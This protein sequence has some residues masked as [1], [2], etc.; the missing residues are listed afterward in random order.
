MAAWPLRQRGARA[1]LAGPA[2]PLAQ[3]AGEGERFFEG[4]RLG[5][6]AVVGVQHEGGTVEDEFVLPANLVHVDQ[7]QVRLADAGDGEVEAG[8]ALVALE[9][10]AVD[11]DHDLGSRF[12]E[13]FGDL[14]EPH[15]L[16]D[17]GPEADAAKRYRPRQA[18]AR[19]DP[20]LVEDPVV[21][22]L[23]LVAACRDLAAVEQQRGI[24][25]LAVLD[26]GGAQE[27]RRAAVGSRRGERLHGSPRLLLEHRL[28]HEV[29]GG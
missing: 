26:P 6:E 7:R 12:R 17:H 22:E 20:H 25:E 18:R 2:I 3:P 27:E 28:E 13:T 24:V 8:V 15:V 23:V 1:R 19:K 16:A 14:G 21:G 5:G 10:R 9:G 11:R 29:L 4:G